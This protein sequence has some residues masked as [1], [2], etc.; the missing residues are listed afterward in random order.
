MNELVCDS[1]NL[2]EL[3]LNHRWLQKSKSKDEFEKF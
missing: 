1:L 3:V 2:Y